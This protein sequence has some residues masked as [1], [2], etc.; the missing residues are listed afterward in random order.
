MYISEFLRNQICLESD[1]D[2]LQAI[3]QLGGEEFGN[4]IFYSDF[5]DCV[6]HIQPWMP[7]YFFPIG[8]ESGF[9][10]GIH[11]RPSDIASRRF[12]IIRALDEGAM[13]EVGLSLRH[14]I[15]RCLATYE[16]YINEGDPLP[17]FEASVSLANR[18]FGKD[19]Y[20]PGSYGNFIGEEADEVA[21]KIFGK[22]PFLYHETALFEDD[23]QKKFEIL[24]EGITAEPGCMVLY[25]DAAKLY[26]K[27]EDYARAAQMLVNSLKCFHHTAYST[28]LEDYYAM[29]R[30]LLQLLPE[31]FPEEARSFLNIIDDKERVLFTGQPYKDGQLVEGA[32]RLCDLCHYLGNYNNISFTALKKIY[33][34]LGWNWALALCD[35]RSSS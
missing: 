21:S 14:Y 2:D 4:A 5:E 7:I 16:G 30:S 9:E 35:L 33:S 27:L 31:A 20:Q 28:D 32:K 29:S 1:S 3:D 8:S 18:I 11:L 25:T 34:E 12:A 17:S 22:S 15:F 6:A 10:I 13:I 24:Q 26:Y 19:F 23:I